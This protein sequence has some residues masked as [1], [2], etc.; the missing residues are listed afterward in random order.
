MSQ[1][2]AIGM[3]LKGFDYEEILEWYYT[4]IEILGS[5]SNNS[6]NSNDDNKYPEQHIEIDEEETKSKPLLEKLVNV[7]STNWLENSIMKKDSE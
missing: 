3:A 4:D 7:L 2:G 5:K 1:N 6:S